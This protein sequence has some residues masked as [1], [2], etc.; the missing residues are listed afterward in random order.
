[1]RLLYVGTYAAFAALGAA[2]LSRPAV[3]WLRG[4]GLFAPALPAG[5]HLGWASAPLLL[6]LAGATIAMAMSIALERTPGTAVHAAFLGLVACAVALRAASGPP[7]P[8]DPEPA[9]RSALGVLE[10]SRTGDPNRLAGALMFTC[11]GRGSH[12]FGTPDHDIETVRR[13]IGQLPVAGMFCAGEIGQ[14]GGR[15]FLHGFTASVAVFG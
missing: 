11:N 9:L 3:E 1:V 12:L 14:V 6:L 13:S 4:L 15:N 10:L 7:G 5:E 8:S 2:L